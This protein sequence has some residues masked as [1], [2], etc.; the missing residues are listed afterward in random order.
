[1]LISL[2]EVGLRFVNFF[3]ELGFYDKE[4]CGCTFG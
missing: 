3:D 2:D 1:M 4:E